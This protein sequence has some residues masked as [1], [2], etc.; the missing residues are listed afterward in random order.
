MTWQAGITE[1]RDKLYLPVEAE[2]TISPYRICTFDTDTHEVRHAEAGTEF[3]LGVSGDGSEVGSTSY[4]DG[5]KLALTYAGIV[6]IEMSGSGYK[7]NRIIATTSGKGTKHYNTE[8]VCV[9]GYVMQ[10]FNDGDIV[11]VLI[12]RYWTGDSFAT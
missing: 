7:G 1:E 11:P 8:G 12:D 2:S 9:L 10:N 5:D 3:A 4:A 6:Y